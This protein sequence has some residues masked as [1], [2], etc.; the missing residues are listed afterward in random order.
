MEKNRVRPALNPTVRRGVDTPAY[1]LVH[2]LAFFDE[3][4]FRRW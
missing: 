1:F 4:K 3:A 2:V